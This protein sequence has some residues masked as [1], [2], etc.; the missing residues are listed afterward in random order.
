MATFEL[1]IDSENAAFHDDGGLYEVARLLRQAADRVE[2]GHDCGRCIDVNG[3]GVGSWDYEPTPVTDYRC[4]DCG[5]LSIEEAE[6]QTCRE[7]GR[8]IITEET[9]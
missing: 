6:G 1:R 2:A 7:C 4:D 8:G 5:T 3:N 9:T